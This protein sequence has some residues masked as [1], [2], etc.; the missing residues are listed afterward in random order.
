MLK[1]NSR[2]VDQFNPK[3]GERRQLRGKAAVQQ[4]EADRGEEP[5]LRT[6]TVVPECL[7]RPWLDQIT[8]SEQ[9]D[10]AALAQLKGPEADPIEDEEA[11]ISGGRLS[12]RVPQSGAGGDQRHPAGGDRRAA[13]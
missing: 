2:L 6:L 9:G 3:L 12:R 13:A 7:A 4:G 11:E 8:G 1:T 5:P 10:A